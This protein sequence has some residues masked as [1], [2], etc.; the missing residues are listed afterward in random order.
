MHDNGMNVTRRAL[1]AAVGGLGAAALAGCAAQPTPARARGPLPSI[2]PLRGGQLLIAAHP[3]DDLFFMSPDL[4]GG[5]QQRN[6]A[7]T[8]VY[9]TAGDTGDGLFYYSGREEGVRSAYAAMVGVE[10]VWSNGAHRVAGRAVDVHVLKAE[11][12][13]RLMFLHLPDGG[14]DGVGYES[15]GNESLLRLRT[16]ER[17]PLHTIDGRNQ[18]Y[19]ASKLTEVLRDIVVWSAPATVRTLDFNAPLQGSA[20]HADHH[21]IAHFARDAVTASGMTPRLVPYLGYPVAERTPNV[22]GDGL[23]TKQSAFLAYASHDWKIC[24]SLAECSTSP[25]GRWLGRQ[26]L[27]V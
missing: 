26:Y 21:A 5:L 13:V 19:S 14:R 12:S 23:L 10:N 22:H 25:E 3:D 18:S 9:A 17:T 8:T 16:G 1:L 27:A 15:T 24:G 2:G 11:P 20:D 4:L 7:T 6:T